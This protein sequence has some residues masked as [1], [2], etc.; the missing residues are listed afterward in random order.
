[1]RVPVLPQPP[2]IAQVYL[3]EGHEVS[4]RYLHKFAGD[5]MTFELVDMVVD[6][7]KQPPIEYKYRRVR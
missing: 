2:R 1:M 5:T 7:K 4:L 3:D 6:G